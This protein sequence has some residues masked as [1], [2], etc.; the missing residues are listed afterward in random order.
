MAKGPKGKWVKHFIRIAVPIYI[1]Q[2]EAT[3][4]I[5]ACMQTVRRRYTHG[6]TAHIYICVS[7]VYA[8]AVN[9]TIGASVQADPNLQDGQSGSWTGGSTGSGDAGQG[10]AT[11]RAGAAV[12]ATV[13]HA[14]AASEDGAA[15]AEAA[16]GATSAR[17]A[18][19]SGAGATGR[20]GRRRGRQ[21]AKAWG[22]VL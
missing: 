15:D 5:Y 20:T 3:R 4:R 14:E 7:L 19:A 16:C 9:L 13:D 17:D 8:Y 10:R 6:F 22:V 12:R 21:G 18:W 2:L 11:H 1:P